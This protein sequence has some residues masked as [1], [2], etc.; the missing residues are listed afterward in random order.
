M[1]VEEISLGIETIRTSV[2]RVHSHILYEQRFYEEPCGSLVVCVI[3]LSLYCDCNYICRGPHHFGEEC[4][5]D[6]LVEV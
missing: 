6:R 2:V 1:Q 5:R 3:N 4:G